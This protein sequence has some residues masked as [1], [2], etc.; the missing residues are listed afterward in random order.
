MTNQERVERIQR[1]IGAYAPGQES[2]DLNDGRS[3][4]E[5]EKD[6]VGLGKYLQDQ[7]D[8]NLEEIPETAASL[9]GLR[10]STKKHH[11]PNKSGS[12]SPKGIVFH[13][14]YGSLAGDISWI[15][16]YSRQAG[17]PVSYHILIGKDGVRH[18]FVDFWKKAWH[19]GASTFKGRYGCNS[20]MLG[21]SFTGDTYKRE[22]TD[23]ELSSAVDLVRQHKDKYGW[24]LDWMTDHRTVSPTRKN[25]LNPKEWQRLR[26]ALKTVF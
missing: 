24:S 9:S 18:Q 6:V 15:T 14:S 13:H 2:G 7:L 21:V 4:D 10:Y 5:L 17:K 20:F 19:A 12:L 23:D 26:N 22:L 16:K 1:W 3:L 25:D 11:T 8:K